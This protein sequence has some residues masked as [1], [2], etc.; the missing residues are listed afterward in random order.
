MSRKKAVIIGSG[1]G[2]LSLGIRLQSLGFDTTIFEKLDAPGGRAYVRHADGFVFDMG[3]TVLT[4]PHF[5]E[6]LFA[7]GKDAAALGE[8]D[9]PA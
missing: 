4:V 5:I 8:P 3:P 2:G 7:L 1:I 9:F 6:E